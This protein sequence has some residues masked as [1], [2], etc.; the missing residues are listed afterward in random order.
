ME[1]LYRDILGSSDLLIDQVR[2]QLFG[3]L[4][5]D[6]P[7]LIVADAQRQ[8]K[9]SHPGRAGVL[10]SNTAR[11]IDPIC[12][13]LD[14]GEDP[15]LVPVNGGCIAACQLATERTHCGYL[16]VYLEGYTP[17]T[18]EVNRPLFELIFA[19][20]EATCELIEKNNQLHHLRL[21]HLSRDSQTAGPVR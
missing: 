8:C 13:R 15:L 11:W 19:Q 1:A 12:D 17:Q 5:P 3:R 6:G 14:D 7:V 2:G 4:E 21:V 9:A 16:L 18:A 10:L 20:A